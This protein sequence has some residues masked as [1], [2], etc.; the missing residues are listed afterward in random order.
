MP[1]FV[2]TAVRFAIIT[3]SLDLSLSSANWQAGAFMF[4]LTDGPTPG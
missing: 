1:G 3:V 4:T 2:A